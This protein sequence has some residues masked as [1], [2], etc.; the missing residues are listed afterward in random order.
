MSH[1][2][3][4]SI[5]KGYQGVCVIWDASASLENGIHVIDG[6][7]G[8]GKTTLLRLLCGITKPT[9]G[10]ILFDGMS[11]ESRTLRKRRRL[12]MLAAEPRFYESVDVDF[13][14]RLHHAVNG[15]PVTKDI[16]ETFDPFGLAKKRSVSFGDL[17]L[18]WRKRL[19]LHV[20]FSVQPDL[21]ILDEPTAGLDSASVEVVAELVSR[22]PETSISVIT[23]HDRSWLSATKIFR[24]ELCEG[25][26]GSVLRAASCSS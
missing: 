9:A 3:I 13:A 16:F 20:A 15:M 24:H 21:L 5:R 6:N 25:A 23:S 1:L 7:N 2:D 17:S 19:M 10:E 8:V 14:I 4:C 11:V 26:R 12:M 18:G 22:R